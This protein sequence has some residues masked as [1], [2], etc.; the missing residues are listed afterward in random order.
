MN[1]V[2][3]CVCANTATA[4]LTVQGAVGKRN[5]G[6][7]DASSVIGEVSGVVTISVVTGSVVGSMV[8]RS[9]AVVVTATVDVSVG[10]VV[11]MVMVASTGAG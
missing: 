2:F 11:S 10:V 8:V 6:V 3:M 1:S 7:V 4:K 9:G 5:V